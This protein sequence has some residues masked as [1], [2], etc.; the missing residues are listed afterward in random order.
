MATYEKR[1]NVFVQEIGK[2]DAIRLTSEKDRD[3]AGYFW[4]NSNRILFLKDNGGDENFKLYV[5]NVD[6]KNLKCY[7]DFDKVRTQIIDDLEDIP[8]EVII[9]LNKRNPEV[10]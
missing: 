3:I 5:V 7:T 8:S 6:G 1:M 9:G 2:K 10:F 4:K